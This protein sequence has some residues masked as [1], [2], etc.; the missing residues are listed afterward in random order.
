M[1][2]CVCCPSDKNLFP[3]C[4]SCRTRLEALDAENKQMKANLEIYR[5]GYWK[6]H[7]ETQRA[8]QAQKRLLSKKRKP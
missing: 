6:D 2:K 7:I 3:I 1:P 8:K 5:R 4:I